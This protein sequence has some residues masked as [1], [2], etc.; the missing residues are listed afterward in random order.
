MEKYSPKN[1]WG[2]ILEVL[3]QGRI[4]PDAAR[5]CLDR[6]QFH[7]AFDK[8]T[9]LVFSRLF[10]RE[11][12]EEYEITRKLNSPQDFFLNS[13][14]GIRLPFR[15][16]RHKP[17]YPAPFPF[18][19]SL[20]ESLVSENDYW[21]FF[22]AVPAIVGDT[23]R[24]ET[25][26]LVLYQVREERDAIS[27]I[28]SLTKQRTWAKVDLVLFA[29]DISD[30]LKQKTLSGP[31]RCWIEPQNILTREAN[32]TIK[33]LICEYDA[34]CFLEGSHQIDGNAIQRSIGILETSDKVVQGLWPIDADSSGLTPFA[35]RS[36]RAFGERYPSRQLNG[37]NLVVKTSFVEQ[38][39]F[40][41]P[42]FTDPNFAAQEFGWRLYNKGA[43]FAPL[44]VERV[45]PSASPN[46]DANAS[47]LRD[48][49]PNSCDRGFDGDF[50]VP[51]VS[52]YIP[53]Y[54]CERYIVQAVD[55][56]LDQDFNDLE[57][58]IAVDGSPDRTF[59][60]L[61]ET[62]S[63]NGK[64][65]FLNGRNGGIG[66]ASNRAIEMSRGMY[67]GQLDSDDRLKPGAIR[68]LSNH[69]DEH[70]DLTCCY[71]SCERI[72]GR[73]RY[74]ADEYSW[75]NFSREKM[76]GTSIAHHF[77]MFRRRSWERTSKFRTDITNAVDYDMFLK[78]MDT[79]KFYH[80]NE[81]YYQRRWHGAN[82]SLV[83]ETQ[84][85]E[86][87]YH[88][89]RES[90]KRMGLDEF[91]DVRVLNKN[92]P[93]RVTYRRKKNKPRIVFWPEY[94]RSNP[95]QHLLYQ[96]SMFDYEICGGPVECAADL[97]KRA[98]GDCPIVFHLH[99]TSFLTT[100]AGT[101]LEAS[102]RAATFLR[103]LKA[104]KNAGGVF[105]WTVHNVV[106][107][108]VEH[109]DVE[110]EL[111]NSILEVADLLHFHS[112]ESVAEMENIFEI[113][114]E[115]VRIAPHGNYAGVYDN[116]IDGVSSREILQLKPEDEVLLHTGQIRPY[117][118]VEELV[119]AF[120]GLLPERKNLK[121]VLAG[122]QKYDVFSL[123]KNP[124]TDFEKQKILIFDRFLDETEFQLFYGAADVAVFP[125]RSI[126]TSGS[127]MLALTFGV[128]A[129]VPK[130]GMTN[131]LLSDRKAGIAYNPGEL[132]SMRRAIV[133]LL[134]R[135]ESASIAAKELSQ[136]SKW[137]GMKRILKEAVQLGMD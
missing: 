49:V 84:Q 66:Y 12:G 98:K 65:R 137:T 59:D 136:R 124:L 116:C 20:P 46:D 31:G 134:D 104:F 105:I 133:D 41:D 22:Q 90:L 122:D 34:F 112:I 39:G 26:V 17:K 88:V 92:E 91:W 77:R 128:P 127:L 1:P 67:I 125:Y 97:A 6:I 54:N 51:K 19:L 114:R 53:A 44:L 18:D 106:S 52:I 69:L 2:R 72:N 110:K 28:E 81:T 103:D 7:P 13:D 3:E 61:A 10:E 58:C 111:I 121:L 25:K 48:L 87:T 89:Q 30:K 99:W 108:E 85:T 14:M 109:L 24:K 11:F 62:F 57:I 75:K 93:R 50:E 43:W 27:I 95:Y 70:P 15:R 115:K 35:V 47:L 23:P 21:P 96:E 63:D 113:E 132:G 33:N 73:G 8:E 86:N 74:V 123:L 37:L 126:L 38:V 78:L 71:S 29:E 118:G 107:H 5:T 56:I 131:E 101:S 9:F 40:L 135:K 80:L 130:V 42:R 129:I 119:E 16:Y 60:L 76:L 83:N 32:Q 64:V 117:K 82:T 36:S 102:E 55:S 79:G 100:G 4:D 120:R 94:G 45:T 68:R